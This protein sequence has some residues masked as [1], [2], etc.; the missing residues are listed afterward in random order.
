VTPELLRLV[1]DVEGV[2][3]VQAVADQDSPVSVGHDVRLR[4][5]LARAAV[6]P[7]A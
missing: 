1:V 4:V 6:L 3:E 2:G 7:E 5:D